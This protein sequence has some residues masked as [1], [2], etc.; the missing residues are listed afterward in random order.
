[1]GSKYFFNKYLNHN[2]K[3]ENKMEELDGSN[4][5]TII[6]NQFQHVVTIKIRNKSRYSLEQIQITHFSSENIHLKASCVG[7]SL[8]C[9]EQKTIALVISTSGNKFSLNSLHTQVLFKIKDMNDKFLS[10]DNVLPIEFVPENSE[11]AIKM[12]S[13]VRDIMKIEKFRG[14]CISHPQFLY[15]L[16][17]K[18]QL[19]QMQQ[20]APTVGQKIWYMGTYPTLFFIGI[21]QSDL[22]LTVYSYDPELNGEIIRQIPS[23]ITHLTTSKR[24]L[25]LF[26]MGKLLTTLQNYLMLEFFT[27]EMNI[28][29]N[30]LQLLLNEIELPFCSQELNAKFRP[31]MPNEELQPNHIAQLLEY[32]NNLNLFVAKSIAV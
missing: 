30:E 2:Y 8:A 18:F 26:K 20:D 11:N 29:V 5:I 28:L 1:M 22:S 17:T 32:I 31:I 12:Y 13:Y 25:S 16:Q 6:A 24:E 19:S 10:V 15:L 7:F 9:S 23:L 4:L 27:P 3:G 14:N 21:Q